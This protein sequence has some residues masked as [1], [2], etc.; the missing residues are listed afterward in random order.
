MTKPRRRYGFGPGCGRL[1]LPGL[2]PGAARGPR[3][4]RL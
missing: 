3:A 1:N 4:A 2:G